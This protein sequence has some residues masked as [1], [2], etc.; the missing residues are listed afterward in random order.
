MKSRIDARFPRWMAV[1]IAVGVAAAVEP[2]SAN[3]PRPPA[4]APFGVE[5]QP[6]PSRRA[7]RRAR[8]RASA[9]ESA[10][11]SREFSM[12]SAA[13][14][15]DLSGRGTNPGK[16]VVLRDQPSIEDCLPCQR[17]DLHLPRDRD[18]VHGLPLVVWI[19]GD[20]WRT[21]SKDDCPVTWLTADGYAVASVGYRLSAE[22][23]FP[24]QVDDCLAA[25]AT[26]ARD[27]EAWGI[28]RNRIC[29]AG[30]AAGGHLAALTGL[31]REATA[32]DAPRVAA[33]GLFGAP[34]QLTALGP[35]HDRAGSPASLLVGGPLPEFREV[36]QRASP[37][38]HVAPGGPPVLLVHGRA[39]TV[40]PP[41]QSV[42]FDAALRA[43][44]VTSRLIVLDGVGHDLPLARGT[45]AGTALV[46][47]LADTIGSDDAGR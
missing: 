35:Q 11:E 20:T 26:L 8:R 18:R 44:G 34:S 15:S 42:R 16:P 19:H 10:A 47:F 6:R 41:E 2:L 43:A 21:G 39:D 45:A 31:W 14:A 12:G 17:F 40:V 7:Q 37:V 5:S 38:N 33:I 9:S 29:V 30:A 25:L 46:S 22:A 36:A 24:A 27:A 23:S 28:D 1:L 13:R 4:D 3:D 32:D